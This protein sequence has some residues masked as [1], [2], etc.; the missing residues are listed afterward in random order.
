MRRVFASYLGWVILGKPPN[1]SEVSPRFL[2][3]RNRQLYGPTAAPRRWYDALESGFEQY[4]YHP[5]RADLCF[6][7]MAGLRKLQIAALI[8]IRLEDIVATVTLGDIGAFLAV[9][10]TFAHGPVEF[11]R[12]NRPVA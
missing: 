10:D 4:K 2:I 8:P 3:R 12:P 11:V 5:I 9:F 7:I 6:S 1:A